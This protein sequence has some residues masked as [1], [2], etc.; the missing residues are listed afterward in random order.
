MLR[1]I[2]LAACL[3][4]TACGATNTTVAAPALEYLG[5]KRVWPAATFDGTVIGGLSGISYDAAS[6]MYYIISDD[7]SARNP[8]R[9]YTARIPLSANGIDD[10]EFVATNP[11]LDAEGRPFRP[12]DTNAQPPVIP[13]DPEGIA[14]DGERQRL[15]WSSEG[16][17]R[18]ENVDTP[19]VLN[20][21]VRIAG[22]DGGYLGEFPLPPV[23]DMSLAQ[24]AGPRQNHGLEGLTLTPTGTYLYAAMEGPG[25][26]DGEPPTEGRRCA[27]PR[28]P[29]RRRYRKGDGA[30]RLPARPGP[31]GTRRG[32]RTFGPRRIGRR[33]L[34]R[35]RT[36]IR[37][38]TPSP[39]SSASRWVMPTT[40]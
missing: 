39:A 30:V 16:E 2:L 19:A 3:T 14:V 26:N 11:W 5:Q 34:P 6:Q 13:P 31:L 40:C 18:T 29:I 37:H 20:T 25:H 1:R 4:L 38:R 28:H 7:R 32:Q 9:F 22:L 23:L 15:Y 12:L 17:R 21:W 24:D 10:V 35:G 8:A 27:D 33:E 36:R